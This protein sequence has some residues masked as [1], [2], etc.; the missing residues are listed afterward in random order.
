MGSDARKDLEKIKIKNWSKVSMDREA[1]K[2]NAGQAKTQN[3]LQLQ[4]KK[5][6]KKKKKKEEEEEE[7]EEKEEE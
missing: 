6:K 7:E 4:V 2:K 1:W 3:E 5:K